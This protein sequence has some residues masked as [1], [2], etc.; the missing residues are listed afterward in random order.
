MMFLLQRQIKSGV[1]AKQIVWPLIFLLYGLTG[2]NQL[3][4]WLLAL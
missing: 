2:L 4:I 3:L 1:E